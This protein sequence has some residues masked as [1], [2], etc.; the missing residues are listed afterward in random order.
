MVKEN[1]KGAIEKS[2]EKTG[3]AIGKGADAGVKTTKG[4]FKRLKKGLKKDKE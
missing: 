4:F 3:E 1:K 2:A